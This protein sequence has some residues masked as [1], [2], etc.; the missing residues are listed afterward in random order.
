MSAEWLRTVQN[1]L[2]FAPNIR[3][4][5]VAG[6]QLIIDHTAG[7]ETQYTYENTADAQSAFNDIAAVVASETV[8]EPVITSINPVRVDNTGAFPVTLAISGIAFHSSALIVIQNYSGTIELST[9]FVNSTAV[10][11]DIAAGP[12]L[13]TYDVVYSDTNGKLFRASNA[14]VVY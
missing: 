5:R 14:I 13:G 6:R 12:G 7:P 2:L 3:K 10:T 11:A 1:E 8:G 4:I 9:T